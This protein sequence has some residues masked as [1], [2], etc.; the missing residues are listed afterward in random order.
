MDIIQEKPQMFIISGCNGSGKTTASYSLLPQLFECT[1]FVNTD[2]FAKSINPGNP[3][4]AALAASRLMVKKIN[5]LIGR[6]VTFA[7]E[8][9]LAV[10]TLLQTT[11]KAQEVGYEVTV[12]Y[13]W[14]NSPEM[15]IQRVKSR[16]AAGGHSIPVDVIVRRYHVGLN[17]FL[18]DYTRICDKWI[19]ADNSTYPFTV[20][21]EGT[22]EGAN[23]IDEGKYEQIKR[24]NLEYEESRNNND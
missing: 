13:F 23:I 9:T 22:R 5:Y 18:N 11:R 7:I 10:R 21:A 17:Y 4:K 20:V 16:V 12:L 14:L 15:A 24:I 3:E 19:L 6:K 8:S 2:E 1:Q